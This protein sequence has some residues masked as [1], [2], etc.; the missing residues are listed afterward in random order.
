MPE[1]NTKHLPG[2]DGLRFVA[3]CLVIV[4]HLGI[5]AWAGRVG[6]AAFFVLSGYL[7]TRILSSSRQERIGRYLITFYGR[8]TLRICPLYYAYLALVVLALHFGMPSQS[9]RERL[10]FVATYSYDFYLAAHAGDDDSRLFSHLW[11]LAVEEQ[12]YLLWPLFLYFCPGRYLRRAFVAL[13]GL[14]PVV[15]AVSMHWVPHANYLP[16]AHVDAFA[17][18]ASSAL[19]PF[20]LGR[21]GL[22]LAAISLTVALLLFNADSGPLSC[23]SQIVCAHNAARVF[24]FSLLNLSSVLLIECL[25]NREVLTSFFGHPWVRYGGKISYGMYV[26]HLSLEGIVF[27][28]LPRSSI[29][30]HL[31]VQFAATMFIAGASFRFFVSPVLAL[32]RSVVPVGPKGAEPSRRQR[33]FRL[34]CRRSGTDDQGD[35]V[36]P[37]FIATMKRRILALG[38]D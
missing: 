23:V 15:R 10:P 18:G 25:V 11:T 27:K 24:G 21:R 6:V 35:P 1:P 17:I 3:V 33:S 36:L 31:L 13:V 37:G 5:A 16:I 7:I 26:F 34:G 22:L 14:G 29:L 4:C 30:V 32:K 9:A 28:A 12:F 19:F 38:Y 20:R 8:R 2:L